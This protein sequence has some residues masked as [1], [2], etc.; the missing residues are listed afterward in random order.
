[1]G[2]RLSSFGKRAGGSLSYKRTIK[3]A[4]SRKWDKG[5]LSGLK[6]TTEKIK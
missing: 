4:I 1:M 2:G 6:N 5:V 3:E